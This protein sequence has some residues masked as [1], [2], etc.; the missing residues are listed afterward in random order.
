M[1]SNRIH[2]LKSVSKCYS[3]KIKKKLGNMS[4]NHYRMFV[5]ILKLNR[6]LP[7]YRELF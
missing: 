3:R 6:Q 5:R 4:S 2:T 7:K 1:R